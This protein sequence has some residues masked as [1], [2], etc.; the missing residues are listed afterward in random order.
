MAETDATR[1]LLGALVV[2]GALLFAGPLLFGMGGGM[3]SGMW[4]GGMT[5]GMWGPM[6]DGW[7]GG[8]TTGGS[9]WWWAFALLWRLALLG[10]LV[11]V[12]YLLYRAAAGERT[13]PAVRELRSA[14][15]RGDISEEEY[16]RRRE[17][18]EEE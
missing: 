12:G 4:G 17:R 15:A 10:V 2:L 11:V 16:E 5:G 13:D 14:Y 18:L 8:G 1:W 7:M 6:H 9:V 3:T